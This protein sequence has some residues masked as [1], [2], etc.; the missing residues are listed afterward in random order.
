[1]LIISQKCVLG[2]L[3]LCRSSQGGPEAGNAV[4]K[5]T[6][7][8]FISP[9][10]C[11]RKKRPQFLCNSSGVWYIA[12]DICSLMLMIVFGKAERKAEK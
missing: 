5:Q 8:K 9:L 7:G 2:R 1:M 11:W 4:C 12:L 10:F 6:L 3:R